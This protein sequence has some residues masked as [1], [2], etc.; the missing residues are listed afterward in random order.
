ML[1]FFKKGRIQKFYV[2]RGWFIRLKTMFNHLPLWNHCLKMITLNSFLAGKGSL[3][4]EITLTKPVK[5]RIIKCCRNIAILGVAEWWCGGT[6]GWRDGTA[7]IWGR[8]NKTA[9]RVRLKKQGRQ[10]RKKEDE[11]NRRFQKLRRGD[12]AVSQG[13]G[14]KRERQLP[15][16]EKVETSPFTPSRFSKLPQNGNLLL[17]F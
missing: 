9:K 15:L 4:P 8:I 1:V 16:Q 7:P 2:S 10:W 11:K 13:G 3:I 12:S 5:N 6:V 17:F 14:R